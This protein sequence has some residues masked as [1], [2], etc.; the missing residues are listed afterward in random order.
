MGQTIHFEEDLYFLNELL[1][2]LEGG[3][4]LNLDRLFFFDKIIEDIFFIDT[5]IG[6]LYS[7]LNENYRIVQLGTVT[8]GILTIKQ[9]FINLLSIITS[10]SSG[11]GEAFTPFVEKFSELIDSHNK[12]IHILQKSLLS[13]DNHSTPRE[14]IS[15]EEYQ[16]LFPSDEEEV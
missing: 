11:M 4:S 10:G 6:R 3:I 13:P 16:F 5:T 1:N 7:A 14:G 15:R 8:S 12:D 9:R 2:T